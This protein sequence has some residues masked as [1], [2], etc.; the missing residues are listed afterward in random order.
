M[1]RYVMFLR[2]QYGRSP[3]VV[4]CPR[5][6]EEQHKDHELRGQTPN[7]GDH[8]GDAVIR[9]SASDKSELIDR[10]QLLTRKSFPLLEVD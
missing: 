4:E 8:L 6:I 7:R 3:N 5:Y 2:C 1:H 9:R 10:E